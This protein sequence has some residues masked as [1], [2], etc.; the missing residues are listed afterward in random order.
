MTKMYLTNECID[1]VATKVQGEEG[2]KIS[3]F[4]NHPFDDNLVLI[5]PKNKFL[6]NDKP[7]QMLHKRDDNLISGYL[8]FYYQSK[9]RREEMPAL[10]FQNYWNHVV[11][12]ATASL[13]GEIMESNSGFAAYHFAQ[14]LFVICCLN[15]GL[16]NKEQSKKNK[17]WKKVQKKYKNELNYDSY[18]L[19]KV[20][21]TYTQKNPEAL[22]QNVEQRYHMRR[23]HWRYIAS[24][25]EKIWIN[26]Y[27]AGNKKLGVITKDYQTM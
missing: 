27:Y 22:S 23:G 24:K 5:H 1:F 8:D 3:D 6:E 17:F 11:K 16:F 13:K 10:P 2:L 21:K 25:G 26:A 18:W 15:A 14:G 20:G 4:Y 19:V 7:I 12:I 9:M